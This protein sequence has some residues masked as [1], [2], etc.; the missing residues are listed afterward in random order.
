M[1]KWLEPPVAIPVACVAIFLAYVLYH[2]YAE[3]PLSSQIVC[4]ASCA[5]ALSPVQMTAAQYGMSAPRSLP[6]IP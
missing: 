4:S 3:G 5:Y 6:N 1:S 2:S